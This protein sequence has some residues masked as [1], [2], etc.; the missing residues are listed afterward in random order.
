MPKQFDWLTDLHI[1][2]VL[3]FVISPDDGLPVT[4]SLSE[5]K[6]KL[7]KAIWEILTFIYEHMIIKWFYR[8]ALQKVRACGPKCGFANPSALFCI[9]QL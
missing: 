3:K 8:S 5:F 9:R 2:Y 1:H 7:V 6:R 4:F